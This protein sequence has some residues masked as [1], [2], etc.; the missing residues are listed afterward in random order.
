MPVSPDFLFFP[1]IIVREESA[2][3]SVFPPLFSSH[4]RPVEYHARTSNLPIQ[5]D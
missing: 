4:F 2:V 3:A 1:A 5:S